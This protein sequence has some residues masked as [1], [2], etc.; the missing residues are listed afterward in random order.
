MT[1][2]ASTTACVH[3]KVL[4][5]PPTTASYQ[6]RM[7]KGQRVFKYYKNSFDLMDPGED[8]RMLWCLQMTPTHFKVSLIT[9]TNNK[10]R[11][12]IG[13]VGFHLESNNRM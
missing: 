3:G 7:V 8:L 11:G 1:T 5:I 2:W 6:L 13:S 12:N 4:A 9:E 10:D